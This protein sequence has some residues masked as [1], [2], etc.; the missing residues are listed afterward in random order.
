MTRLGNVAMAAA[1]IVAIATIIML[2][3]ACDRGA[4]KPVQV[5]NTGNRPQVAQAPTAQNNNGTTT[6]APTGSG[7]YNNYANQYIGS[8]GQQQQYY[9][10]QLAY[11]QQ[12]QVLQQQ[13]E[14][15]K[16]QMM[17]GGMRT[18]MSCFSG[19][20]SPQSLI[21]GLAPAMMNQMT[22]TSGIGAGPSSIYNQQPIAGQN[23]QSILGTQGTQLPTNST[24][25]F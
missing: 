13:Q 15:Q 17:M 2:A 8:A 5:P 11:Q 18:I 4:Q 25:G 12:Q 16:M 14:Q 19:T 24:T 22:G 10:Q 21:S 7:N 9:Q 23:M 20:C 3:S 1:D 6:G